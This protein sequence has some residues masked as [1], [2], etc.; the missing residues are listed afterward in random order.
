MEYEKYNKELVRQCLLKMKVPCV[1]DLF[2]VLRNQSEKLAYIKSKTYHAKE[3]NS[4]IDWS[5]YEYFGDDLC[6]I[7]PKK[8]EDYLQEARNQSSCLLEQI[9]NVVLGESIILFVRKRSCMELSYITI[10]LIDRCIVQTYGK[11]NG[12][13]TVK[14]LLFLE[15]YCVVRCIKCDMD[16]LTSNYFDEDD[17]TQYNKMIRDYCKDYNWRQTFAG[18]CG[19]DI[20]SGTYNQISIF[21]LYEDALDELEE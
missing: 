8:F 18:D 21:D 1:Q 12:K 17:E 7:S 20:K 19:V 9:E 2:V 5:G 16:Q 6:V 13:L 14:E 4:R 10:E 3:F 15:E 11:F